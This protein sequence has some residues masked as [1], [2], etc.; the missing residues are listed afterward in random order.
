MAGAPCTVCNKADALRC[1]RCKSAWYCGKD[2]QAKDWAT[3]KLLCGAFAEFDMESRPSA[4]F[5]QN[6]KPSK[7]FV[8]AVFFPVD[9]TKPKVVWLECEWGED[10]GLH[11]QLPDLKTY[12]GGFGR[13]TMVNTSQIYYRDGFLTDGSKPNKS[14]EAITRR[15]KQN[16]YQWRGPFLA[17]GRKGS[18]PESDACRD[19]DLT[20]FRQIAHFFLTYR[21]FEPVVVPFSFPSFPSEP[22]VQGVRINCTGDMKLHHKPHF[23]PIELCQNHTLLHPYVN[24]EVAQRAG[25]PMATLR[26]PPDSKLT[27]RDGPEGETEDPLNNPDGTFLHLSCDPKAK[28]DHPT[29]TMG[30]GLAPMQYQ[31]RVG[32]MFVIRQDGEPLLPLHVEAMCGYC[33]YEVSPLFLGAAQIDEDSSEDLKNREA[34]LDKINSAAFLAYW[35]KMLEEKG[36]T[37]DRKP[38]APS[39]G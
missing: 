29:R 21:G 15:K 12:L 2:C 4:E 30:F 8:Q 36:L 3:H 1:T 10:C 20:D 34:V 37:G 33:R 13:H 6:G 11:F 39:V 32:S 9:E 14:I 28:F 23:E 24:S 35:S 27:R 7:E 38:A 16:R 31:S 26:I 22:M 19:I 25:I 5:D 17:V 18:D